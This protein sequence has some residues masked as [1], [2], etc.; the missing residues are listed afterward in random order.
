MRAPAVAWA[1]VL[2]VGHLTPICLARNFVH[3]R[4]VRTPL[5]TWHFMSTLQEGSTS[6]VRAVE[7]TWSVRMAVTACCADAGAVSAMPAGRRGRLATA[8]TADRLTSPSTQS[9]AANVA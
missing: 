3:Y 1:F 9:A 7:A 8:L 6:A 4:P 2:P 5:K